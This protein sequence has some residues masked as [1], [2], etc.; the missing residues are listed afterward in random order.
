MNRMFSI[1]TAFA[2]SLLASV[3]LAAD[4]PRIT[5]AM[6]DSVQS[7]MQS[8]IDN[9]PKNLRLFTA[10]DVSLVREMW[11][12][13]GTTP[14]SHPVLYR[15]LRYAERHDQKHRRSWRTSPYEAENPLGY[16]EDVQQITSLALDAEDNIVASAYYSAVE[17]NLVSGTISLQIWGY[18]EGVG[19]GPISNATNV[20]VDDS[21]CSNIIDLSNS[22]PLA[23]LESGNYTAY[24]AQMHWSVVDNLN[25][26]MN[27]SLTLTNA[28]VPKDMALLAPRPVN[29]NDYI[30]VCMNRVDRYGKDCDY[31]INS[32]KEIIAFPLKGSVVFSGPIWAPGE[33]PGFNPVVDIKTVKLPMGGGCELKDLENSFW[34]LPGVKVEGATVSW[35]ITAEEFQEQ[36]KTCFGYGDRALFSMNIS[37]YLKNKEGPPSFVSASFSN[38]QNTRVGA[39][40]MKMDPMQVFYGCLAEDTEVTLAGLFNR[41]KKIQA[42]GLIGKTVANR[43]G[44]QDLLVAGN[45]YGYEARYMLEVSTENNHSVTLTEDHPIWVNGQ[46]INAIDI[47]LKDKV[48]TSKG[49]EIVTG[50]RLVD[51]GPEP[52]K[53]WNIFLER[54]PGAGIAPIDERGFYANG[55]LVGDG[56]VQ[57]YNMLWEANAACRDKNALRQTKDLTA[58]AGELQPVVTSAMWDEASATTVVKWTVNNET[59]LLYSYIITTRTGDVQQNVGEVPKSQLCASFPSR[60]KPGTVIVTGSDGTSPTGLPS[61]PPTPVEDGQDSCPQ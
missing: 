32:E 51:S 24:R 27:S 47:Q 10:A 36:Q 60:T 33:K 12:L 26:A 61:S 59:P 46:F 53:V 15:N 55:I 58:E 13:A 29:G 21:T 2:F 37:A 56:S 57:E 41:K 20:N 3:V 31:V 52:A 9:E 40:T 14:Q 38:N 22:V 5:P 19:W 1:L 48:V 50:L 28:D 30:K 17:S 16:T 6:H 42:P 18:S 34:D 7:H 11:R 23:S 35:D 54:P 45:A 8:M 43:N 39:S 49:E 25:R 44:I 4:Q